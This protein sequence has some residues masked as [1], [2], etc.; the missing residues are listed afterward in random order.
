M[1]G[2]MTGSLAR[3]KAR[4]PHKSSG[5][6]L[7]NWRASYRYDREQNARLVAFVPLPLQTTCITVFMYAWVNFVLFAINSE[8]GSPEIRGGGEYS[9]QTHGR[10]IRALSR[11]EYEQHQAYEVRAMSGHLMAFSLIPTVYF[12]SVHPRL[13]KLTLGSTAPHHHKSLHRIC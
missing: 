10:K 1:N 9:L 8:G 4:N 6:F 2:L 3:F 7:A 5:G 12:L 11:E 13:P